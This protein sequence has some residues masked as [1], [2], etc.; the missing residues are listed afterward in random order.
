LGVALGELAHGQ[1]LEQPA[2]V[3]VVLAQELGHDP[4]RD[5][6]A[7]GAEAVGDHL[8][9]EVGPEEVGVLGAAGGVLVQHIAEG[10]MD[11]GQGIYLSFSASPFLRQRSGGRQGGCWSSRSP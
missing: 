5:G 7:G 6:D 8:L 9:A 4:P 10:D 3:E 11:I 2:A 1:G